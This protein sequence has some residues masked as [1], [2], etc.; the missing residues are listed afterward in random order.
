MKLT[1]LH[2]EKKSL[3]ILQFGLPVIT[4]AL[5][6]TALY[7]SGAKSGEYYITMN[8][9]KQM[10]EHVMMS[11]MLLIGGALLFDYVQRKDKR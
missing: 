3:Y 4:A 6:Y 1:R 8:A 9:G 7:I 5:L 11:L 10:L 2:I